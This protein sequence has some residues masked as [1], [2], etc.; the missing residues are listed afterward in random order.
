MPLDSRKA[1]VFLP[2]ATPCTAFVQ[3]T[4]CR[5]FA[6]SEGA[7]TRNT[8]NPPHHGLVYV[9]VHWGRCEFGSC[10]HVFCDLRRHEGVVFRRCAQMDSSH[11]SSETSSP[12]GLSGQRA[13]V[14]CFFADSNAKNATAT[15]SKI[16][17]CG[18]MCQGKDKNGSRNCRKQ[19]LGH[20]R[21]AVCPDCMDC[22]QFFQ[23]ATGCLAYVH[24]G[25]ADSLQP[26]ICYVCRAKP[27]EMASDLVSSSADESVSELEE[28][29]PIES[30][31]FENYDECHAFLRD[32]HFMCKKKRYN[33]QKKLTHV[34]YICVKSKCTS[35]ITVRRRD[36]SEV[37][38]AP[39]LLEHQV[40]TT[41]YCQECLYNHH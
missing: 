26:W 23:C 30:M 7:P 13:P 21:G 19:L 15:K 31:E 39:L 5:T 38:L 1:A 28:Q 16:A 32:K 11:W 25:C 6:L 41:P 27:K 17:P 29:K 36:A 37:W 8:R 9:R 20:M 14:E 3:S 40:A 24:I 33:K 22:G 18:F 34:D 2:P 12:E 4:K 10:E 35:K